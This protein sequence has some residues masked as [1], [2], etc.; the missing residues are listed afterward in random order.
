MKIGIL[1]FAHHHGEAYISNLRRMDGVE[2]L[3]VAD[4]DVTRGEMIARQHEV[5]Y[6]PS[7]EALLE[8]NHRNLL[9]NRNELTYQ[10]YE[11]IFNYGIPDDGGEYVFPQYRTG[12]FRFS[13]ISRH[14]RVYESLVD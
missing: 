9:E 13:G 4:D 10:Q 5:R 8:A 12:P 14:K 2:L 1:S 6:F 11:D 7:Y 3:G